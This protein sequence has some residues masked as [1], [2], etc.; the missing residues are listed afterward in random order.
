[1]EMKKQMMRRLAM[2]ATCNVGMLFA[3]SKSQAATVVTKLDQA[4]L[5]KAVAVAEQR[6][7]D[8]PSAEP[9]VWPLQTPKDCP[10]IPSPTLT[11]IHFTGRHAEYVNA[12]TWY[13]SWA[14]DGNLYSPWTDGNVNGLKSGSSGKEGTTGHAT[15]LGDDPLKLQVVDQGVYTSDSSPYASRYPCG[16]LVYNGVWYYGTYCLHPSPGTSHEG[17]NYNWPW[18]GPFVGFRYSTDLGKSWTQTPCTPAKPLFGESALHGEPV[19]M[20][21]PH[22]VDFGKN[23]EHSPDGKAYLVAHG[24]SDGKN[25]RFGYNSWI[26]GDEIYLARVKPSIQNMNDPTKY[27][28]FDGVGWTGD[29]AK[30]KP[31]AAWRDNMGCV[32]MTYDAPLKKYLMCVTDGGNTA[33]YF[34]TYI[35]ESDCIT[36]P[37]KLVHYLHHFGEQ[38]YFVNLP[39]KFISGD[40]RTLW[41]CY[42]ANFAPNWNGMAIRCRPV[43]SRY[44]MC[45]HEVRLLGS[46]ETPQP[47][48]ANPLKNPQNIAPLAHLEASS[49][50]PGYY[51]MGAVNGDVGGCPGDILDEWASHGETV[52]AWIKLSWDQPQRIREVWLFDRPNPQDQVTEG[53]LEFSDGTSIILERPLPDNARQGVAIPVGGK[54]ITWLKFTVTKVK[55]HSL[56]IGLAEIGV[57]RARQ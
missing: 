5:A 46:S 42:S 37:F 50:Y 47:P 43:G 57:F 29:F 2:L 21:S 25:R 9:L 27:E 1:M 4:A 39:S 31:I 33:G 49:T 53:K 51:V 12:D 35:L 6:L 41:L 10:F 34:N 7:V 45:L 17:V 44:G 16:S 15:I 36:G 24:A 55:E 13:P 28:F 40:G 11:G 52:G 32:T 38:A 26:T 19:K 8:A 18:L 23:M 54:P 48:V 20:G 22:V 56:N 30:I 14:S 3:A